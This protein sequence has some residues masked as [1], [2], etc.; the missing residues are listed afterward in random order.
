MVNMAI[1]K[2]TGKL[3]Q[4]DYFE[5]YEYLAMDAGDR[6]LGSGGVC[7]P[8][9]SVFSGAGVNRLAIT[10]GKN[11]KCYITNADNLG[12]Y[13][14]GASGGDLIVQTLTPPSKFIFGFAKGY[15]F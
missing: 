12:G 3:T 15:K 5:P 1:N 4:Q 7:L 14:L 8:D 11:A 10:C 9:P 13:K 2:N 6:D